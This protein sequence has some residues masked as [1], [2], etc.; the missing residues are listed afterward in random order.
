MTKPSKPKKKATTKPAITSHTQH[1]QSGIATLQPSNAKL[2]LVDHELLV[3]LTQARLAQPFEHLGLQPQGTGYLLRA[4]LPDAVKV[5]VF[6]LGKDVIPLASLEKVAESGLFEYAFKQATKPF[7]YRL[8]ATY[9]N[10]A[11]HSFVDPYQFQ[12]TAY[13]GLSSLNERPEHLYQVLGAQNVTLNIEGEA[14]VGTRFAVFAPSASS[15]SLIADFNQWDGR[16]H[17]MQRSLCGHWVLFVPGITAGAK[18]KY[19]LK[20]AMGNRLP[21]K[22]DP[23]G[24]YA[25]Q[26]PSHASIVYDHAQYQWQDQAWRESQQQDKRFSAMNIYEVHLG[27]WRRKPN[28]QQ[29]A[30]SLTYDEL[31]DELVSYVKDM[32]YTHIEVMPVSEFPFDGSWGYQPVGMFA[33]TSRFGDPDAFKRFVDSCHQ[34]GIGVIID[35]V[36][37]HFPSDP[38]GLARFD[39]TPLY[40]YEDPRRGWH[41]DWNSY[42]Y[43][44]G[45]NS[46]RQFLV[47]SA[48]FWLDKFHVDGLR[49]DAVASMLYW[50]Y[51]RNHGEWVPNVDGGNHNYEAISLLRWCNEEVYA[52]YPHAMTIAE[53]STSFAGVSK[54]TFAGG[55]G[56]GFKWN[57][58]WM[59]DSLNYMSKDPM[60]RQFHHNEMTFAMVYHYNEHFILPLSH[61]E[62][63]HGKGSLL[64][65]MPGDEWQAAANL[66][67]Y[68]GFMF[69]HPGKKIN[70]MGN[71]LA[72]PIEW[73]HDSQLSWDL[74]QFDKHHGH[75]RLCKDL[76]HFYQAEPAM[77]EADYQPQGFVWLDHQDNEHSIFAFMRQSVDQSHQVLVVANFTPVPRHHYRLGVPHAGEYEVVIN[78][79]SRYYWGSNYDVGTHFMATEL[80]Y[81]GQPYS[82]ALNIPPL[83]TVYLR[84]KE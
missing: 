41:P 34:Q 18:Y 51:S 5:E 70:F 29:G 4:W 42:I 49:V 32:G 37:A 45:N 24:F 17:P 14:I 65:K 55:L 7:H 82:I 23:V 13:Q 53:E 71:E 44:F 40:E 74:L 76:G 19:E 2:G 21:H 31:A 35:W 63:V 39:G 30:R 3:S 59:H 66:R 46:V 52:Q 62:V 79:D 84:R 33:P 57:M 36:P 58:G 48:L 25:E 9:D 16:K 26:Y 12:Q 50:D 83:A 8:V 73:N 6:T 11:Q 56:F 43:D 22:A 47:A 78:T 72:Q 54:P 69:A 67:A 15:V 1:S 77:Y 64:A 10:G 80:A 20:D 81:Q 38:H 60:Y 27:S 28:G 68:A 61:D 75:Q